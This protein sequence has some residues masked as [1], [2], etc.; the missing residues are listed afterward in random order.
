VDIDLG[1]DCTY[2]FSCKS[3]YLLKISAPS[4]VGTL[5]AGENLIIESAKKDGG[6]S[7]F[8]VDADGAVLYNSKFDIVN[9]SNTQILIRPCTWHWGW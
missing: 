9:A 4:S 6:K 2:I 8:K 1:W 7:V 5:L 3:Q